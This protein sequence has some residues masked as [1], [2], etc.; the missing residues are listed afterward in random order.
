M[1]TLGCAAAAAQA[2][3]LKSGAVVMVFNN[4]QVRGAPLAGQRGGAAA[5]CLKHPPV[6][7]GDRARTPA[8]P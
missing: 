4:Y 6:D 5:G 7:A 3:M 2:A 1:L 8:T